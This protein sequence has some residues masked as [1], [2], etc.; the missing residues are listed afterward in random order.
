M[1]LRQAMGLL[2]RKGLIAAQTGRGTFVAANLFHKQQQEFRSFTEEI[3]HRGGKPRS[4]VISFDIGPPEPESSELFHLPPVAQVYRLVRV[5][6][7]ANV[8]LAVERVELPKA[9]CPD[10]ERYNFEKL[11]LYKV[12]EESYGLRL[13]SSIDEIRAEL[14]APADRKLLA[15]PARTVALIIQR[16]SF[17]DQGFPIES[18]R[19]VYR[20]DLYR[21]VVHSLRKRPGIE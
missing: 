19:S 6:L 5:R 16:K 17:T 4:K 20:G 11:S 1:T 2:E 18:S 7:D 8:P 12:L 14:P 15:M 3:L 21:A 13:E 9:L 10:L